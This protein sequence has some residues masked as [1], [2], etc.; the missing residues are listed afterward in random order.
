[1]IFLR[2]FLVYF[3]YFGYNVFCVNIENLENYNM[4]VLGYNFNYCRYFYIFRG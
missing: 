4:I 1:M 2:G 3:V